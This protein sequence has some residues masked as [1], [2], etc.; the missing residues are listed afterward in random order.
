MFRNHL[1]N[2]EI[3]DDACSDVSWS[4]SAGVQ[5]GLAGSLNCL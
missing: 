5:G 1:L 3:M 2:D 4:C